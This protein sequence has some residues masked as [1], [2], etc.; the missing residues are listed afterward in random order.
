M[1][2]MSGTE[3][4][5]VLLVALLLLGPQKLPE[6]AR[7]LGKGLRDFR[8]TTDD[9]RTT[10]ESEFYRMDQPPPPKP[11]QTLPPPTAPEGVTVAAPSPTSASAP[12]S[13][14]GPP[15][16]P[17]SSGPAPTPEAIITSKPA[18]QQAEAARSNAPGPA[19]ASPAATPPVAVASGAGSDSKA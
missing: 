8:K 10:V 15:S 1:F 14:R 16:T 17:A 13:D 3:L 12:N 19:L 18:A 7:A 5:I 9:V 11:L 2:G 6:L 4:A